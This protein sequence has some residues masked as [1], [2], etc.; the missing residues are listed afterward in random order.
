MVLTRRVGEMLEWQKIDQ[1]TQRL[2]EVI[3]QK[4]K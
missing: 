3:S 4:P 2:I 1:S